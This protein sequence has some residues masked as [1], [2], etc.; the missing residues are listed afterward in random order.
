MET[1]AHYN[2]LNSLK[3]LSVETICGQPLTLLFY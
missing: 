2:K 3:R 1:A